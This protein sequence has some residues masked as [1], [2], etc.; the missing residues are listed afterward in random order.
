MF[1]R[2][3]KASAVTIQAH[4]YCEIKV[5]RGLIPVRIASQQRPHGGGW[6]E[7]G[8]GLFNFFLLALLVVFFAGVAGQP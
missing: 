3:P 4:D 2:S 8:S 5:H 7:F 1:K 6:G